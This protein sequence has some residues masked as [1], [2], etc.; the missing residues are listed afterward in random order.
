MDFKFEAGN[1][2][3]VGH[4]SLDGHDVVRIECYPTRMF[5]DNDH[6]HGEGRSERRPRKKDEKDQKVEAEID[7]KMNKTALV[8]LWIDPGE[9]QIVR[10]TFDNVWMDFL[11]GAW[12][13]R[14]DDIH[15]SMTMSQP[16][17]GVWLPREMNVHA[18]I[19]LAAGPFEAAYVRQFANYRLAEVK[20]IIRVPK[21]V[22]EVHEVHGV[23]G[24]GFNVQR[25]RFRAQEVPFKVLRPRVPR[26]AEPAELELARPDFAELA[27]VALEPAEPE[28]PELEPLELEPLE[29]EHL[30]PEP[31]EP[32]HPEP[33]TQPHEPHEPYEPHEPLSLP[34]LQ[35]S[36][37][38]R[39][40][41]VHGNAAVA[42]LDVISLAGLSVGQPATAEMLTAAEARLKQSGKFETVEVRKR[43]RSLTDASD[44]A[45]LLIVHEKPGTIS[46][47]GAIQRRA[48]PLGRVGDRLMFLPIVNY[49]DGYGLTY[50]GRMSTIGLFGGGERLSVPLTWGGTRRAAL[51]ADRT[52][53]RGPFTRIE[54][55]VGI[56]QREN[57]HFE[58]D[59]RRVEVNGRAER[60]VAR[61]LKGGIFASRSSV[62]FGGVRRRSLDIG[63]GR[64]DRHPRG[65]EL[66][67]QRRLSRRGVDRPAHPQRAGAH[68]IY[69][70]DARGYAGL[71]G[72]AVGAVRAQYTT[73]SSRLPDYERLLLGG[74][75]TLRGFRAGTFAGDRL[76]VTSAEVRLPMTSVL[77]SARLGILGFFDAGKA[78][79]T[80]ERAADTTWHQG[81]GGGVFL[82]APLV[83]SISTSPTA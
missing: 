39:E 26:P 57:P 25:V 47:D 52:F 9:R 38:I 19:S 75:S 14:V 43:Y 62:D 5:D 74:A 35:T 12:L 2:Y 59:D 42:D 56:W 6:E 71:L 3:L 37:T 40:I 33:G 68:R 66:P 83:D 41:R 69:S 8:T 23:H 10:Y 30:E 13:V 78:W 11:P 44:V 46:V 53:K 36:E 22:H 79:D 76:L 27:P 51:E 32:E 4:E 34:T 29:P 61:V 63:A 80:T 49:A 21:L 28:P 55:S 54:S 73:A 58:L 82:I 17:P 45:I 1:Y 67:A 72:Q 48:R 20:S 16:F 31:L 64:G 60:R 24:V 15:A 18:G 70:T 81:A 7:R 77:N 65:S 50:G